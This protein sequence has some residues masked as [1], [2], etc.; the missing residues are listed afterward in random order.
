MTDLAMLPTCT[1]GFD[2]ELYRHI[3]YFYANCGKTYAS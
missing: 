3:S 2:A 1:G